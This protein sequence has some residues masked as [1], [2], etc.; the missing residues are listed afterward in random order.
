MARKVFFSILGTS[1]YNECVYTYETYKSEPVRFVQEATLN[2]ISKDWCENSKAY[3]LLTNKA[4]KENWEIIN[5]ERYNYITK[6]NENYEGLKNKLKKL[7]LTFDIDEKNIPEG[8]NEEEMWE[9]FDILLG[10][11]EENDELYFDLTHS[12]RYLPMLLLVF[13]NYVKFLKKATIQSITYGNYENRDI[14]TNE[15]PIVNLLPISKLQD[16]TFATANY[17]ENGSAQRLYDLSLE[18]IT[19]ILSASF[20]K[21]YNASNLRAFMKSLTMVIE[22]RRTCRGMSIYLSDNFK[23]LKNSADKLTTVS[24]KPLNPLIDKIRSSFNQ[25]SPHP[26][27]KNGFA[28]ARWCFNFG[29]YQQAVTILLENIVSYI[30]ILN[31]IQIN[32]EK[33]RSI[34]NKAIHISTNKIAENEWIVGDE[35][36]RLQI[37]MLLEYPLLNNKELQQTFSV[38]TNVR[39]DFNHSGMRSQNKP[40]SPKKIIQNIEHCLISIELILFSENENISIQKKTNLLINLSNHPSSLWDSNQL[41][42]ASVYGEVVDI[43]FPEIDP[44]A[45]EDEITNLTGEFLGKIQQFAQS[46]S[47]TVHL[48]GE[49]TFCFALALALNKSGIECVASTT[50]RDV[51]LDDSGTKQVKFHFTRFRKYSL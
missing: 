43:P 20:G 22:E 30:C 6:N 45:T 12:F 3:I 37:K 34:I 51:T 32:D 11:T 44:N 7:N 40:L 2:L 31:K 48:M 27:V 23:E 18:E 14:I 41:Q 29:L 38:L 13:G 5:N 1:F 8:K 4:K 47:V 46:A 42:A 24:I 21:D 26:D 15:A 39:N 33:Q 36:E 17:L 19:P 10:L 16:W 35:D 49:F 28:A 9:I 25:F 50:R